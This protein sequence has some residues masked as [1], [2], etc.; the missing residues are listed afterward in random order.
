M[1]CRFILTIAT[2]LI[3]LSAMPKQASAQ[4]T[5]CMKREIV[6]KFLKEKY[7]EGPVSYGLAS[8]GLA[9]EIF[10]S[11]SGSW[12]VIFS[13]PIGLSCVA[14]TGGNWTVLPVIDDDEKGPVL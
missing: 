4:L 5:S 2:V 7:N 12:T 14:K 8:D 6:V 11:P 3:A 1:T 10:A 13:Y 9:L